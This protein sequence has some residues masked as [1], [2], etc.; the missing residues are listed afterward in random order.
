MK[1]RYTTW[2][3]A[4]VARAAA[5]RGLAGQCLFAALEMR[6]A[7]PDLQVVGGKVWLADGSG[8]CH[9]WLV[10]PA[11]AVLDPTRLQFAAEPVR[12]VPLADENPQPTGQ[13]YHCHDYR[14]GKSRYCSK[15]CEG[16]WRRRPKAEREAAEMWIFAQIMAGLH[17]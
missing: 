15:L 17:G 12:Y 1:T 9:T 8:H 5:G 3:S 14:Y 2:I 16:R 13:C 11:G 4:Y 6:Q 7:F 10:T